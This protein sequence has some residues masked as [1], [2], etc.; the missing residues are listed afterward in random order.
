MTGN[1]SECSVLGCNFLVLQLLSNFFLSFFVS[2]FL[3]RFSYHIIYYLRECREYWPPVFLHYTKSLAVSFIIT[4]SAISPSLSCIL[5]SFSKKWFTLSCKSEGP[6]GVKKGKIVWP[7]LNLLIIKV[8]LS[9]ISDHGLWKF[10]LFSFL[11]CWK[12]AFACLKG[13]LALLAK[14]GKWN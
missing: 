13:K 1:A 7:D 5:D 8:T 6:L 9:V 3:V 4:S 14:T 2:F 12:M 10:W 11:D